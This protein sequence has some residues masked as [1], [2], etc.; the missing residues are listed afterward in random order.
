MNT[1]VGFKQ[2]LGAELALLERA[3]AERAAE[4]T[5]GH[6]MPVAARRVFARPGV[7]RT[8]F[9]G[10]A[11]GTVAAII[12]ATSGGQGA[13]TQPVHAM[14]VAQVLDAAAVNA[15]KGPDKEPGLHQWVYTDN[16]V[17]TDDCGHRPSWERY[18][19]VKRASLSKTSGNRNVVF[20]TD[21]HPQGPGKVG[22]QPRETRE[23]LSRLPTDPR[24]LLARV[25]TDP[26]F[27]TPGDPRS[28]SMYYLGGLH[29]FSAD[30]PLAV[31][32]EAQFT[33]ILNVLQT[34]STIPPQIN[35]ALYRALALIPGT[36]LVSAP[37]RDAAGRSGITIAFDFQDQFRSHGYLFLDPS[38]YAYRGYRLDRHGDSSFSSSFA[39]V[40]TGIV[41]HPGQV[42][43][44]PAPDSSSVVVVHPPKTR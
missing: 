38:T 36:K 30:P 11:A 27:A 9:V 41:D 23:V 42:P 20:V 5:S 37:M 28:A 17:C 3:R 43:G 29:N 26:F 35:A 25:S 24:K 4:E 2:R 13:Q 18:D 14:T 15:A 31:T 16:V 32:P 40:A 19:G 21:N 7:R 8:A 39:R 1:P 33:R 10:L 6:D 22:D 12:V 44:G 34:A